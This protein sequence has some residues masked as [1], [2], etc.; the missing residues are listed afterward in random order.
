M[1]AVRLG[2]VLYWAGCGLAV[3]VLSFGALLYFG[4]CG[5]DNCLYPYVAFVA[6]PVAG[7]SWLVGRA[8]LYI[9]AGE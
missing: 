6:I 5:G 8:A 2:H 1:M 9:L 3:L 7:A 4:M